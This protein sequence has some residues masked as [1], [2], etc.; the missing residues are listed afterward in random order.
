MKCPGSEVSG[1][2]SGAG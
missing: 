1:K 2:R